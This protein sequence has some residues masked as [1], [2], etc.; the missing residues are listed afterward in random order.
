MYPAVLG[1][2]PCQREPSVR[3][4]M[5]TV[6]EVVPLAGSLGHPLTTYL[7]PPP[8]V[9]ARQHASSVLWLVCARSVD[10]GHRRP[11]RS[12]IGCDL[13]TMMNDVKEEAPSH[14]R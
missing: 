1:R 7:N 12:Q 3:R 13:A 6:L 4:S 5:S 11:H 9:W 10:P 2:S 8:T 14:G